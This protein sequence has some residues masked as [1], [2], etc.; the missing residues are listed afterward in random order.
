MVYR[1][2][3]D[4]QRCFVLLP[5]RKPFLGYFEQIIKPAALEAGLTAVK[6]DD[7]Y[8]TRA[9][10]RDIWELIWTARVVVAIVTD[11]NANVNYELGM[12]HTLG[13][14]TIL[15]TEREADVPFDYRHRR[16]VRYAPREAGWERKLLE[17]LR[18]TIRTVL[19]SPSLDE[20]LPWPYDTF[21]LGARRR[22]GS[23]VLSED[24]LTSV[25]NGALLVRRSIAPA[26]GPHGTQVS[27]TVPPQNVQASYRR[28]YRI[29]QGIRSA[30]PLERQ[31]IEQMR[32]LTQ[33]VFGS[34][35]DAA[36]AA[37]FLS[38]GMI[39]QGCEA[40]K[41][42]CVPKSLV[43]GMQRAVDAAVTHI[44]TQAKSVDADKLRSVAVTATGSDPNAA[45]VI[46]KALKEVGKDG[47]VEVVDSSRADID[48][49]LQE[50]MQF[51]TGFLS[52]SFVTDSERQECVL[53][54]CYVL[55]YEGKI[56]SM[57]QMLPLLDQVARRAKPL[58]V[59]SGDLA[60]EALATLIVNKQRGTLSS[61]AVKAPGHADRRRALLEDMAVLTGGRAFLLEV[62]RPLE[63]ATLS[64][65]GRA[66]KVIVGKG[67]TTI[68]GGAGDPA[69]ISS[70]VQSLRRQ[71]DS[72][73]DPHELAKLRE[74]LAKLAGG[75][76]VI[77]AGGLTDADRADSRYRL[78][79]A[80]YSC[81]SAIENGY[82][83]GGGICFYKAKDLVE[84]LVAT[85]ESETYG[86]AAV[87][88][89][90]EL[91]LRQLIQNSKVYNKEDVVAE[92]AR[93]KS[94]SL[95]FNAETEKVEDLN[96]AG[97][98]DAA[99]ALNEALLLAFAHAKGI[100]TTGA[101]DAT[102]PVELSPEPHA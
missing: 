74:R 102:T 68:I 73:T 91:P 64:D 14:P 99:K 47:V 55:L 69:A 79:S 9:V 28:G 86:I 40:L 4:Q 19:S 27:I 84:K 75:I 37:V 11:Q 67:N 49:E 71:I 51:D 93:S 90:L 44:M 97:I 63:D 65:L 12:C 88:H 100:L 2:N 1:P 34:V 53:E 29:A 3:V 96:V 16:Y 76:A 10:I 58:L 22:T 77:R 20:D 31:G 101:W 82:V 48:V 15:V 61:V 95:G 57:M 98:L 30:D 46:L 7:I 72:S 39:E 54:D 13:V 85:N 33:E 24:S 56:G 21:D 52:Q 8:G 6:A 50:G 36:K 78:E 26:F 80:L 43:A 17:D 94:D 83:V 62:M 35:G 45:D 66:Q 38:C 81:H 59:I 32:R 60:Q 41:R 18:N 89:A 23:L 42:G 92:I 5:L 70:R 25:L 87:S